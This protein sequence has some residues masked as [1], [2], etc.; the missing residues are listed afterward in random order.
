MTSPVRPARYNVFMILGVLFWLIGVVFALAGKPAVLAVFMGT[1]T[2]F[3]AVGVAKA[4]KQAQT[5]QG[6]AAQPSTTPTGGPG[7]SSG[8]R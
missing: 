4:K 1:G 2:V 8:D 7:D 5:A 3:V 6:P